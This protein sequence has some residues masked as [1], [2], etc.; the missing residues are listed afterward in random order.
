MSEGVLDLTFLQV[1]LPVDRLRFLGRFSNKRKVAIVGTRQA[2]K[3]YCDFAYKLGYHLSCHNLN[4][5]SGLAYGIDASAH[6]GCVASG[7][8]E[9]ATAILATPLES[10]YPKENEGLAK[11]IL[12]LKGFVGTINQNHPVRKSDFIARNAIIAALSELVIVV[13]GSLKSGALYTANFALEFGKEVMAV[14]GAPWDENCSGTNHLIKEGVYPITKLEDVLEAL[15]IPNNV[16]CE[17]NYTDSERLILA[18]IKSTNPCYIETIMEKANIT[19][20][21]A[22]RVLN[23]LEEKNVIDTD[24]TGQIKLRLP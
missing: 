11:R 21:L 1:K 16:A 4:I 24:F 2:S 8:E 12:D 10:I 13:Q 14:P 22:Q 18:I 20:N 23:S 5:I 7:I 17:N 19:Y 6:S 9:S 3:S 15:N